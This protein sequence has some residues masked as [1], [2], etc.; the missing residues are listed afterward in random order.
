LWSDFG[1]I[2]REVSWDVPDLK[3]WGLST[4]QFNFLTGA[5]V[6]LSGIIMIYVIWR[7]LWKRKR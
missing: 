1:R 3:M 7:Q 6:I 5:I 2:Q 4:W